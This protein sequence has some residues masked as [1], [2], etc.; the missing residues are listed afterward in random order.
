MIIGIGRGPLADFVKNYRISFGYIYPYPEFYDDKNS[1]LKDRVGYVRYLRRLITIKRVRIAVW[2]DYIKP[3]DVSRVVNIELLTKISFVVPIHSLQDISIGETL[4]RKGFDVF[5]GYA[6]DPKFRDY[7]LGYFLKFVKGK[8]WYLGI[9]TWKELREALR[10]DFEGGDIT[11][12]LLGKHK[13]RKN[14]RVLRER[15]LE[16]LRYTNKPQGRQLTL[17]DFLEFKVV[18]K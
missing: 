5:Y 4:E 3:A 18:L 7:T 1:L 16:L 15:L 12:Y 2:P 13:D 10:N 11:G 17:Y 6:S 14:P 9:S 8:K